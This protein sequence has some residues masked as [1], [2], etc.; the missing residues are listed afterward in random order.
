MRC[1]ELFLSFHAR[2]LS[3]PLRSV[4]SE[5]R[6]GKDESGDVGKCLQSTVQIDE[7]QR[8]TFPEKVTV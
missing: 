3:G 6:E 5:E 7:G 1:F 8:S 2:S 4:P